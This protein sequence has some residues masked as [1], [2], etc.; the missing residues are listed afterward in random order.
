MT[1]RLRYSPSL[2]GL[3]AVAIGLVLLHHL[4]AVIGGNLGLLAPLANAGW[5]GVDVF[6]A[7]SGFLITS[8]LLSSRD[9]SSYFRNFYTRRV[10]R[11]F[12]LYYAVLTI[13]FAARALAPA[14]PDGA[15]PS[16]LWFYGFVSNFWFA[17]KTGSSD[18]ALEVTWS[19][20]VEEQFY[21]VWPLLVRYLSRRTLMLALLV[22]IAL[23]PAWRGLLA[24]NA[25]TLGHTLCRMDGIA[26]GA[27]AALW[28][29]ESDARPSRCY[30][31]LAA[32]LWIAVGGAI[33]CGAFQEDRWGVPV[34]E[35]ALV[36]A[37]TSA[38]ILAILTGAAGAASHVLSARPIVW[39]GRVSFGLYLLHPLCFNCVH[40]IAAA[41][42]WRGPHTPIAFR[43]LTAAG[44]VG[45]SLAFAGASFKFFE[46]RFLA[47]KD[48][49]APRSA[50]AP[51]AIPSAA[52]QS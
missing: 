7:L 39:V 45:L 6:F 16:P 37:A 19:L 21:L 3:R 25:Q 11:I 49:L 28:W 14:L 36:P 1:P 30:G 52:E 34:F 46:R 47:L 23:G 18:L 17:H 35:Y 4:R 12:P 50:V 44:A 32:A 40:N 43:L 29:T 2:D 13:V 27:L 20:S 38:T 42:G 5:I 10:L 41:L 8:I 15:N 33:L 24:S 22:V 48:R 9:D 26:I 51:P 31:P